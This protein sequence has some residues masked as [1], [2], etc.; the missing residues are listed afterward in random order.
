MA[1][2]ELSIPSERIRRCAS[3]VKPPTATRAMRSIAI[4]ASA[5]TMVSGL[6]A[7][8]EVDREVTTFGPRDSAGTPGASNSTAT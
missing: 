5:S 6:R 4:V 8:A 1:P 3:T 2:S 7:L